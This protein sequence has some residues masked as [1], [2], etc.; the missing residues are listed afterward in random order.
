MLQVITSI[1]AAPTNLPFIIEK[2]YAYVDNDNKNI[3]N[4]KQNDVILTKSV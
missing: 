1:V 2:L 4:L 3:R